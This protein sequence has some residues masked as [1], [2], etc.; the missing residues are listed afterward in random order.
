MKM[1]LEA[2]FVTLAVIIISNTV[3]AAIVVDFDDLGSS[4]SSGT[5]LY[6]PCPGG[7]Y[8]GVIWDSNI[9]FMSE[10]DNPSYSQPRSGDNYIY[11]WGNSP[12]ATIGFSF[13][14]PQ[15]ALVGAW[16]ATASTSYPEQV[17]FI[18]YDASNQPIAQSDWL[19]L[20]T[21]GTP[22]YLQADFEPVA[23]IEVE[24]SNTI[25]DTHFS[26]DNLTYVPE[27]ASMTILALA[28]LKLARRRKTR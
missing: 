5:K 7:I 14:D 20:A 17:R 28:A 23:R 1:A 24:K 11:N 16:F 15:S 26:M 27:P 10:S 3:Q 21:N 19:T 18:G 22:T 13:E 6:I 12:S 8:D 4:G 25:D 2:L 9:S